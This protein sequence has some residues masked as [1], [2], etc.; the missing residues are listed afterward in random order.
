MSI[1]EQLLKECD[2]AWLSLRLE[3]D[4]IWWKGLRPSPD[5]LAR[6]RR[7]RVELHVH[8]AGLPWLHIARQI[9]DGE[10]DG[11]SASCHA[12]LIIGL[13]SVSHPLCKR[14]LSTLQ[15]SLGKTTN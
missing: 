11:A 7:H 12:S 15:G 4:G 6:L 10:F 8:L 14:A 9:L 5:L 2:D 3:E 1:A 13:R